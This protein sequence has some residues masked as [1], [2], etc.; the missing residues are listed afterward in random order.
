MTV[1]NPCPCR[2]GNSYASCC[3]PLISGNKN[4][5]TA[6]ALMRSRYTAYVEKD[7]NYLLKTWHSSTRPAT[8]VSDT[9]PEWS[10]LHI[11]R[12]EAGNENDN[13]GVVE[14]KAKYMSQKKIRFLHEVSRFVKEKNQWFYVDGDMIESPTAISNKVGRNSPCPCGSGKKFKR[15]CGR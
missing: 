6:E 3:K 8:I 9:I 5:V 13:H 4:A 10:G 1:G 12:T 11:V 14:F 2:S 7:V 15:C